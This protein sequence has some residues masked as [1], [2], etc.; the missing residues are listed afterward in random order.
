MNTVDMLMKAQ[1]VTEDWL[2]K[3]VKGYLEWKKL[4]SSQGKK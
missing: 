3:G 2:F 1:K 4:L